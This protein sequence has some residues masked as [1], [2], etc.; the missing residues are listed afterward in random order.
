VSERPDFYSELVA[1]GFS[2][3][4]RNAL[5]SNFSPVT[6]LEELRTRPWG[7]RNAP[8]TLSRQLWRTPNLGRKGM[9]EVEVFREGGDP[10]TARPRGMTYMNV[11]LDPA[12][13]TALD[14]WIASQPKPLSRPQALRRLAVRGLPSTTDVTVSD[15]Q[16]SW[17]GEAVMTVPKPRKLK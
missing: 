6:S 4:T 7:H 11:P 15:E 13:L 9:A 17:G 2:T 10:R 1:A 12:Q 8:H 16:H 14:A 5:T 3:R